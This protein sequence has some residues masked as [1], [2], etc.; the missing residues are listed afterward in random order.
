[1]A[2]MNKHMKKN[3]DVTGDGG[4]SR[5]VTGDGGVSR[6][7]T[8]NG[9]VSRTPAATDTAP[10][11]SIGRSAAL[12]SV[13]VVISRITGFFRT[14]AQAYAMGATLLASCYTV[15][16]NLPNQLYELVIGGMIV[17]AFLP[18]YLSVK[19]RAGREG[20]N[21]YVSNLLSIVFVLMG[22][23]TV[24]CIAF[25][26]QLVW[27]Q[28]AGTDQA[29]MADAV[30]LFRFFAVEVL[31][32]CLSSIASGVL[33][34]ERDYLWSNAAP[35]F[36]NFITIASFL[37]YPPLAAV[38]P[39]L[40]MLVLAL[41]NPLGVLVQ[42]LMQV[43]SLRRHGVRI[44]WHIDLHDPAI[45]ETLSIGIPTLLVTVCSF[46]T[47]SVMN[48]YALVA[49]PGAGSSV[50]YYARL[51]YTLPYSVL[52]IPITTAM[53]TELAD[54]W[55]HDDIDGYR[56]GFAHGT[57]QILFTL[58]PFMLYLIT[59]AYP[60][61]LL[62]AS[63]R[64]TAD[65]AQLT[66]VYLRWLSLALPFYGVS[67]FFQK[68]FSSMRKMGLFALANVFA[69]AL[70]VAFTALF[71]SRIGIS[72]VALGSVLYYVS[73]DLISFVLIRREL[74]HV[75]MREIISST[76][77]GIVLGLAGA[78]AGGALMRPL[79]PIALAGGHTVIRVLL[80]IIA[81]GSVSL[82]VT[83]GAALALHLKQAAFMRSAVARLLHRG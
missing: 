64:F 51:W 68:V 4:V 9:G 75:C 1:M 47:V 43:P 66:A 38:N 53:F 25:A 28:S 10:S 55:A 48:T 77:W 36:N 30:Y 63:G 23:L 15:A 2:Y 73:V 72:A 5:T 52:S 60:L 62:L 32:Y 7:V 18:V 67:T 56:E 44:T 50:Q 41:G 79:L 57:S 76:V 39:G 20:A 24:L 16:N 6:T 12:M 70:Q 34:A 46:V 13:L 35:I 17:T 59:F 61:M 8:G 22:V 42:V 80:S 14:W 81:C 45:K 21:A 11:Q 74:H 54:R 65:D 3:G 33:N 26:A 78:V 37:A 71:T 58:M 40:G 29:Q 49:E 31:L 69:S 83:F 27:I 19:Q 82:A